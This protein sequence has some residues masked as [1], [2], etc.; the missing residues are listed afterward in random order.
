MA[1][2]EP[3][4]SGGHEGGIRPGHEP[5]VDASGGGGRRERLEL[6]HRHGAPA[7][8]EHVGADVAG[9]GPQPA[10]EVALAPEGVDGSPRPEEGLLGGVVPVVVAAQAAAAVALEPRAVAVVEGGEGLGA[11]ALGEQRE[12]GVAGIGDVGDVGKGAEGRVV[13][14]GQVRLRAFRGR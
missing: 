14:D 11:P 6:G 8:A 7:G 5:V 3:A 12:V 9:D 1:V 10:T 4:E 13:D 2:G